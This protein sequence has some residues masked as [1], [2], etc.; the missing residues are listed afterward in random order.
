MNAMSVQYERRGGDSNPRY[1]FEYTAFPVLHN[2]PLC[3]LSGF[4]AS[5]FIRS[6][7]S[8]KLHP[9]SRFASRLFDCG[10]FDTVRRSNRGNCRRESAMR[11]W[12]LAV[13]G[14]ACGLVV[15]AVYLH[16]GSATVLPQSRADSFPALVNDTGLH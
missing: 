8:G 14:L 9:A 7:Q 11:F 16:H 6:L 5:K 1:P 4:S 2:R 13:T 15:S 3:H 12:W 10:I